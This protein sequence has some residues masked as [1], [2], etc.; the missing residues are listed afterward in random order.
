MNAVGRCL[1]DYDHPPY[2]GH[3]VTACCHNDRRPPVVVDV[4]SPAILPVLL[5]RAHRV[6]LRQRRRRHDGI[7]YAGE[8]DD[9]NNDDDE[10]C[11]LAQRSAS[12]TFHL[13]QGFLMEHMGGRFGQ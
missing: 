10:D 11:L 12:A 5:E 2:G 8:Y 6:L 13:L 7:E 4:V 3:A 1:Y 9:I